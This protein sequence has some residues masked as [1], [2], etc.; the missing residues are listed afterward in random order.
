MSKAIQE[1]GAKRRAA[2]IAT[3]YG[4]VTGTDGLLESWDVILSGGWVSACK[5]GHSN[6]WHEKQSRACGPEI[7]EDDDNADE[8]GGFGDVRGRPQPR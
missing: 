8:L 7:M 1:M 6:K 3:D 2:A 5:T 4:A